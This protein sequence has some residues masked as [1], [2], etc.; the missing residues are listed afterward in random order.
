[1]SFTA[2]AGQRL[3]LTNDAAWELVMV[4]ASGELDTVAEIA[5]MLSGATE[6]R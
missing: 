2:S 1:L 3:I 6:A 4:V 5:G